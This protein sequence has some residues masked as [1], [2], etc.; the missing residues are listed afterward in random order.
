MTLIERLL[1]EQRD[2][3]EREAHRRG[4]SVENLRRHRAELSARVDAK[5][6][7]RPCYGMGRD[8][9][10]AWMKEHAQVG[11]WVVVRDTSWN[12]HTYALDQITE[13]KPR[14]GRFYTRHMHSYNGGAGWYFSGQST[15]DPKGKV[16]VLIP[17]PALVEAAAGS[18][19]PRPKPDVVAAAREQAT[20]LF[21]E[22]NGRSN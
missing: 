4:I 1:A 11:L 3:E 10:K 12:N 19:R 16:D 18:E 20:Q 22:G 6:R 5:T 13:V 8:E 7:A 2:S 14:A 9:V 21:S 17:T 15:R